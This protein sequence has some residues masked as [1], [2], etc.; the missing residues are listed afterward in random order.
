LPIL[1]SISGIL[2]MLSPLA[3]IVYIIVFF[4]KIINASMSYAVFWSAEKPE[5]EGSLKR[6]LQLCEGL[7]WTIFGNYV[8]MGIVG[9]LMSAV[10]VAVLGAV[11]AVLGDAAASLTAAIAGALVGTFYAL[12]QYCLKG[13]VEK[14]RGGKAESH[15][16]ATAHHA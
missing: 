2:A 3:V 11:L 6:S 10:L 14:F 1:P 5:V 15:E 16:K 4:K 12:F 9:V 7:T 8:L 13:Q